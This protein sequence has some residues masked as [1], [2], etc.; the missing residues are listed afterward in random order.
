M[1]QGPLSFAE[2]P[3][4]NRPPGVV[5]QPR[6]PTFE[7]E[8]TV[9]PHWLKRLD[10]TIRSGGGDIRSEGGDLV[11]RRKSGLWTL[12]GTTISLQEKAE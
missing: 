9:R 12:Q 10:Q 11:P 3:A 7:V 2:A 1:E 8:N 6:Q 4:N 5:Y